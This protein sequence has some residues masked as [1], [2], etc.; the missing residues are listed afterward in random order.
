MDNSANVKSSRHFASLI[1]RAGDGRMKRIL[2]GSMLQHNGTVSLAVMTASATI[3]RTSHKPNG[4][5]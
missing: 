5:R 2:I 3:H 1:I 4:E